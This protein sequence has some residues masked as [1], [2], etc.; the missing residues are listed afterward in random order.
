MRKNHSVHIAMLEMCTQFLKFLRKKDV[1]VYRTI[2]CAK[3]F[4]S[5]QYTIGPKG[6]RRVLFI[7]K[8]K[9]DIFS[10]VGANVSVNHEQGGIGMAVSCR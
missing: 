9:N 3:H 7:I 6:E 4:V 8:D 1:K 5:T 2:V 10:H